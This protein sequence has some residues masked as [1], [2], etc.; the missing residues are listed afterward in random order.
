MAVFLSYQKLIVFNAYEG[1]SFLN[2]LK[3]KWK[4]DGNEAKLHVTYQD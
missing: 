3:S 2:I 1:G 4:E